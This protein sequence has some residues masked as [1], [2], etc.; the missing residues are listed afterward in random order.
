MKKILVL[1][2]VALLIFPSVNAKED[3]K[4]S[5]SL[6]NISKC[7]SDVFFKGLLSVVNAPISF[8]SN[9]VKKL[10]TSPLKASYF[11][12]IWQAMVYVISA[13]YGILFMYSGFIFMISGGNAERREKAK[14]Y[15]KN[16]IIMIVLVQA[17][18][19][20]YNI[21]GDINNKMTSGVFNLIDEDFFKVETHNL[22]NLIFEFMFYTLYLIF[23]MITLLLLVMRNSILDLGIV[24]FP[25]GLSFYFFEPLKSYGKSILH[26]LGS[27][28]FVG[29][30][31]SII[32]LAFSKLVDIESDATIKT[33]VLMNAFLI[34]SLLLVYVMLFSL[35]KSALGIVGKTKVIVRRAVS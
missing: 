7:I 3:K 28:M 11:K 5:C 29:F 2:L 21:A 24:I 32:L 26:F 16:L 23:I 22:G 8:L 12:D 10:L 35:I 27:N 13:F 34:I 31:I 6:L 9:L 17:S 30:F 25:F 20:I 33:L 18:F 1:I 14:S 19:F 15:L 4:D